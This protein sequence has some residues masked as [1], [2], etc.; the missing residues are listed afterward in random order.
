MVRWESAGLRSEMHVSQEHH[1]L[2][3]HRYLSFLIENWGERRAEADMS[4]K[5]GRST[6]SHHQ[7][8]T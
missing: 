5:N 3:A 1:Y 2:S 7:G 4:A 6:C 8:P